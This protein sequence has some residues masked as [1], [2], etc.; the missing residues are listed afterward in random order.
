M[1]GQDGQRT[2][3]LLGRDLT[4]LVLR[5]KIRT[6]RPARA[7]EVPGAGSRWPPPST[8]N[9]PTPP[10]PARLHRATGHVLP[11]ECEAATTSGGRYIR[12]RKL[13]MH[14]RDITIIGISNVAYL[15]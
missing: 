12:P 6:D 13:V 10:N 7:V 15:M 3:D 4:A 5:G 1:P 8:R 11:A 14:E 9:G 2:G